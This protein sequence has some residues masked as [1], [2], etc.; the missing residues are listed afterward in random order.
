MNRLITK[1]YGYE[2]EE[3][4]A[5]IPRLCGRGGAA[6]RAAGGQ[7]DPRHAPLAAVMTDFYVK[8][9]D[10]DRETPYPAEALRRALRADRSRRS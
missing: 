9:Q 8:V 3:R 7:G 6:G 4:E 10:E 2:R 5:L 1:V